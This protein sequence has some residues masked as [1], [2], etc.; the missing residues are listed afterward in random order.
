MILSIVAPNIK[1]GGGKELLEY[2][3]KYIDQKYPYLIVHV[4]LD[5]SLMN[6]KI[7]NNRKVFL[8]SSSLGKVFLF[9]KKINNA[10][11]FG[12]LPPFRKVNNSM[13]YIHNPYLV[14]TFTQLWG[15]S[16]YLFFKYSMQKIYIKI[17]IKNVDIVACQTKVVR[18]AIKSIYRHKNIKLFPFFQLCNNYKKTKNVKKYDFCYVSLAHKHKN[19]TL[20]LNTLELLANKGVHLRLA[21]TIEKDK[22]ALIDHISRINIIGSVQ[23]TNMGVISKKAVCKLYS[24]SKCLVFPSLEESFGLGLIEAVEMGLDIIAADLKYVY[25]VVNPS[26]VFDPSSPQSCANAIEKYLMLGQYST[27]TGVIE[28]KIDHLVESFLRV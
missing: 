3:L 23:V 20:L 21:V 5:S 2:L 28:N 7:V 8:L 26:L 9:G 14:M 19:H 11:Y 18:N 12:N 1:N 17:F 13:V 27:S 24:D 4:Y 10:L 6:I 16:M 15:K 22:R 25:E